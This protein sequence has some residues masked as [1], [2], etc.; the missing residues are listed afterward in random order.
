M[1]DKIKVSF[2]FD[3]TLDKK[4]VQ[5]YAKEL[6]ND[7]YEVWIVTARFSD[8][9]MYGNYFM[10]KYG[11]KNLQEDFDNLFK[12]AKEVGINEDHID[13]QNMAPKIEFLYDKGFVWHLDDDPQELYNIKKNNTTCIAIDVLKNDWKL[14]CNKLLNR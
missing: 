9:S 7:G 13:F 10:E 3:G 14:K 11:L 5:K 8:I 12:V 2:D 1:K 6:V 4:A